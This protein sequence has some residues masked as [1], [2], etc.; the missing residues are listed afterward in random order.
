[1]MKKMSKTEVRKKIGDASEKC[2]KVA[3]NPAA[4]HLS[5]ADQKK[6]DQVIGLLNSIYFKL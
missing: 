4:M 3:L 6:L 1:M 2:Q 5:N